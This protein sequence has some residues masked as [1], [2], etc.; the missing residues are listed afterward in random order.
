M[1]LY[2]CKRR[3]CEN[4]PNLHPVFNCHWY[5]TLSSAAVVLTSPRLP[6]IL[7]SG[8]VVLVRAAVT[9]LLT[10]SPVFKL[11]S[12][13][14][15]GC[16]RSQSLLSL[17]RAD[18]NTVASGYSQRKLRTRTVNGFSNS[19]HHYIQRYVVNPK[20]YLCMTETNGI[21]CG[22]NGWL[23]PSCLKSLC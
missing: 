19:V 5:P 8:V 11:A 13:G 14:L 9:L 7:Y 16:V 6:F 18:S 4:I 15:R 12:I 22:Y 3:W 1:P 20:R 21:Q 2:S 17:H 10:L 23:F